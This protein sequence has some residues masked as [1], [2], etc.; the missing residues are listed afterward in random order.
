MKLV[1]LATAAFASVTFLHPL[2]A[3]ADCCHVV[4]C[5]PACVPRPARVLCSPCKQH[6]SP[7]YP[8]ACTEELV[9]KTYEQTNTVSVLHGGFSAFGAGDSVYA[10]DPSEGQLWKFEQNKWVRHGAT[11]NAAREAPAAEGSRA[12]EEQ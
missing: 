6:C 2:E 4:R 9:P 10:F 5:R 8:S 12:P 3:G 7:G 11:L 1:A